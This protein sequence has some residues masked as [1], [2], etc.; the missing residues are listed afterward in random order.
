MAEHEGDQP[1]VEDI[2]REAHDVDSIGED[3]TDGYGDATGVICL[4]RNRDQTG[5]LTDKYRFEVLSDEE[6]PRGKPVH[7]RP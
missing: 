3:F 7:D 6:S 2:K 4:F 1:Q 5:Y